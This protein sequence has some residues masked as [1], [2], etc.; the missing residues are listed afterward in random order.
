M[1][2]LGRREATTATR[3]STEEE[4]PAVGRRAARLGL[5][6]RGAPVGSRR[7]RVRVSHPFVSFIAL[8]MGFNGVF[9]RPKF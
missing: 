1:E 7:I 9:T 6:G 4:G 8:V 5:V 2:R 3:R